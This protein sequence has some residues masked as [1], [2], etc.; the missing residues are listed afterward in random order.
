MSQT[1]PPSSQTAG[2]SLFAA[3]AK[4][5]GNLSV[6]GRVELLGHAEGEIA[7]DDIMVE[8]GGSATGELKAA[9]IA[10]KGKFDGKLT[11]GAV[12]LHSGS[13]VSGEI[14]YRTLTIDSGAD[15]NAL[16]ARASSDPS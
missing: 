8:A 15:V 11:G 1:P 2:R 7:A 4:L 16:C 12:R 13:K 5:T 9:I 6:P 10:I 3:G 14:S